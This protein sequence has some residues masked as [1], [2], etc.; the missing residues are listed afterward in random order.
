MSTPMSRISICK[1]VRLNNRYE[2]TIH[3]EDQSSQESWF[4]GKVVK[5]FSGYTYLRKK[6]SI[7]VNAKM[8]DAHEWDYLFFTNNP[9]TFARYFYYF[10]TNIEY[11]NENTVELFLELDVMQTYSGWYDL[12]PCFVERNHTESDAIGANLVDENLELGELV[13]NSSEDELL[14][15][16]SILIL[17]TLNMAEIGEST[18]ATAFGALYNNVFSGLRIYRVAASNASAL[19]MLLANLDSAGKSDAIVAMWMYP[20]NLI[21]LADGEATA[22]VREVSGAKAMNKYIVRP[23]TV[24]GYAPRNNKLLTYPFSQLYV[25]NNAGGAASYR[26]ERFDDPDSCVFKLVGS[27]GSDGTVRCYPLNYNGAQHAYE[28]GLTLGNFPTCAWNSDV[29]KLWCAQNQNQNSMGLLSAG[30]MTVGGVIGG[31]VAGGPMGIMGGFGAGVS[32]AM[33]IMNT[34]AQRKDMSIQ[35]PQAKGSA[36]SSVNVAAGFQTFTYQKKSVGY[37]YANIIDDYFSLY[38]YRINRV[39]TPLTAAR[40]NWTY[41][42]TVGCHI[43]GDI[44]VEDQSLIES[45][46]DKGITFWRNGDNVGNYGDDLKNNTLD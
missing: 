4:S 42:K 44:P 46:F 19:G 35:P 14:A 26:Y 34:L 40:Q 20:T 2:H 39:M 22:T 38:G 1:G 28:Y 13:V 21:S 16:L 23:S 45:I 25:T 29:Y 10:I 18:D 43:D 32:G 8:E 27:L 11:V 5:T 30:L 24:D 7:K 31:A 41:V 37:T 36:S 15:D 3:W 33:Q 17:T 9:G 12:L 6:W